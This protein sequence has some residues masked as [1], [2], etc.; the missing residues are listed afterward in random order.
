MPL[1]LTKIA[2]SEG[3]TE[4]I[5]AYS[6]IDCTDEGFQYMLRLRKNQVHFIHLIDNF[7]LCIDSAKAWNNDQCMEQH[8][9]AD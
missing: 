1:I 9:G 4:K 6:S 2:F 5:S 8:C 7:G 3:E